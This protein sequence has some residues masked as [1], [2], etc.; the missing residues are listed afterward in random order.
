MTSNEQLKEEWREKFLPYHMEDD[1]DVSFQ[2]ENGEIEDFWLSK[3]DLICSEY[4]EQR[5]E[6]IG[7]IES[8]NITFGQ[9]GVHINKRRKEGAEEFKKITIDVLKN[10]G[11]NTKRIL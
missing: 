3:I 8:M 1:R 10:Y 5:K 2:A 6:L 11:R 7:L 4:E 9:A